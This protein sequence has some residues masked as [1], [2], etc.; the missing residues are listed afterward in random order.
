LSVNWAQPLSLGL[1]SI[2]EIP[3]RHTAVSL[4]NLVGP[5]GDLFKESSLHARKS[6]S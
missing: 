3:P 6:Q 2:V 5:T 4:E 1:E